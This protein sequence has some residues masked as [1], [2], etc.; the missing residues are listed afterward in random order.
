ME[1]KTYESIPNSDYTLR[2]QRASVN[3]HTSIAMEYT[4]RG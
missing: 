3:T 4:L 1:N 2:L